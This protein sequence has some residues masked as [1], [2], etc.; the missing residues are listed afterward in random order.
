MHLVD[1]P[2]STFTTQEL[3]RLAAYRAAVAAGFYTD[4]DDSARA[5]ET[6]E[7]TLAWRLPGDGSINGDGYPF[8]VEE[9]RNL[10][11]LKAAVAEE[12]PAGRYA[13]DRPPTAD[14]DSPRS[15]EAL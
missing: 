6:D 4:W 5:S 12:G 11:R 13:D 8:T 1:R 3:A 10:E 15:S 9:R 7:D 14:A 2:E